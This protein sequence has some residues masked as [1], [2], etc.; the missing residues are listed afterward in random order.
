[1]P[2]SRRWARVVYYGSG[3]Y[4]TEFSEVHS[5]AQTLPQ[6]R[7]LILQ[8][9]GTLHII[10]LYKNEFEQVGLFKILLNNEFPTT[11]QPTSAEHSPAPSP[12]LPLNCLASRHKFPVHPESTHETAQAWLPTC[13]SDCE[14]L[15]GESLPAASA[16]SASSSEILNS[17]SSVYR[18]LFTCLLDRL[19]YNRSPTVWVLKGR[20]WG[21][22][23][24]YTVVRL[25]SFLL[26][27]SKS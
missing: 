23:T 24:R 13:C 21:S 5:L 1:M 17:K 11:C 6:Q 19:F 25:L 22:V 9:S 10:A 14:V 7:H 12:P 26:S 2:S 16:S 15:D 27:F 20:L 3:S 8:T 18:F 4:S